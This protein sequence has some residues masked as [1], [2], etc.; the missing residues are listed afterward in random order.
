MHRESTLLPVSQVG[1]LRH[2]EGKPPP[3][4]VQHLGQGSFHP[5]SRCLAHS[6]GAESRFEE[7]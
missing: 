5:D 1:K 4:V 6:C 2:R 3:K 7:N